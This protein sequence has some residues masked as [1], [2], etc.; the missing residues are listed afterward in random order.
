MERGETMN[1]KQLERERIKH[2]G[3]RVRLVVT[4]G[5]SVAVLSG[6]EG[7]LDVDLPAKLTDA[8]LDDPQGAQTIRN[9]VIS[10]FETAFNYIA[11]SNHGMEDGGEII[12]GSP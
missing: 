2:W 4:L 3:R 11:W 10:E 1:D 12:L 7:L 9:S 8:A 5:C 6:C